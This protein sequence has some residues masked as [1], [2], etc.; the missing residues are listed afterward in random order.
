MKRT[1]ELLMKLVPLTVKVNAASP[2][3]LVVDDMLLSVGTGLSG[4]VTVK[5]TSLVTS[6]VFGFH[7]D[8]GIVPAA[9]I[10]EAMIS[11][12][13]CVELSKV[14]SRSPPEPF[15]RTN[16]PLTK[17]LPVTVSVNAGPFMGVLDGERELICATA[18]SV[19][20]LKIMSPPP[21]PPVL[22]PAIMPVA[23][24]TF[25]LVEVGL[26]VAAL[27]NT[28]GEVKGLGLLMLV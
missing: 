18:D 1:T 3:V 9:L 14:V 11:A 2:A 13:S 6:P 28:H 21:K 12:L 22:A 7:T 17:L 19:T 5:G 23:E 8:T 25:C 15:H 20:L 27:V 26:L 16:E 10:S 4:L 24:L